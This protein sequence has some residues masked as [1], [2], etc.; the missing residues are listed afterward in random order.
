MNDQPEAQQPKRARRAPRSRKTDTPAESD[1]AVTESELTA[2]PA[3]HSGQPRHEPARTMEV[4]PVRA[5]TVNLSQGGVAEVEA[6]SVNVRQGGIGA[7]SAEDITVNMGGIGRAEATD[8]AVR[9]SGVGIAHGEHVSVELGAAG[10]VVGG[11]VTLTQGYAR[12]IF[13]REVTIEKGGAGTVVAGT[14]K[15]GR[16]SGT[17]L[18]LARRVEGDVR[19]LLDWRGAVAIGAALALGV[20]VLGRR[21]RD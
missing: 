5:E 12:T 2:E 10:L 21:K 13:A 8:I 6:D 17:V 15:L 9:L 18:L 11:D 19:T 3:E 16:P 7:A 1:A 14:V 20:A 4:G